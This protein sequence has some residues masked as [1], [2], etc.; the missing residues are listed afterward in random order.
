MLKYDDIKN[1]IRKNLNLSQSK[2]TQKE[3]R[4]TLNDVTLTLKKVILTI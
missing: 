4:F 1:G 3:I 2:K